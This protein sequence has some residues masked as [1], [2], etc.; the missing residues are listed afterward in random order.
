MGHNLDSDSL[1]SLRDLLLPSRADDDYESDSE[2]EVPEFVEEDQKIVELLVASSLL[3]LNASAWLSADLTM[4][5]IL[6]LA[7]PALERRWKPHVTCSLKPADSENEVHDAILSFGL[8]LMEIEAKKLVRPKPVDQD[9]ETGLT[10]KDSMLKR[11]LEEWNRAV[12]DGYRHVATACLRF[13]E[14]SARFY[15]PALT[16]D[17]KNIAAIYKYILAP[18]HRL[19]THQHSRISAL[20][21]G[22]P[23]SPQNYSIT[24]S[25]HLGKPTSRLGLILFDGSGTHNPK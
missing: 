7:T 5:N 3:N 12:G 14:L 9:W 4:K 23:N 22:L 19:I 15:D 8:L 18:L 6:I 21:N 20:F 16:Q 1:L 10:S 25:Q 11:I 24:Q 13:R 2:S 17:M